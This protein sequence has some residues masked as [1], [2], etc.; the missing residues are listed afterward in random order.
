MRRTSVNCLCLVGTDEQEAHLSEPNTVQT[1]VCTAQRASTTTATSELHGEVAGTLRELLNVLVVQ[2]GLLEHEPQDW[3][4]ATAQEIMEEVMVD[5]NRAEINRAARRVAAAAAAHSDTINQSM[6]DAM[7]VSCSW[8]MVFMTYM[9][10][11]FSS[12]ACAHTLQQVLF[13]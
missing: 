3:L 5:S 9:Y 7:I 4:D 2:H 10:I 8:L 6:D 11:L 12:T 1:V 13:D